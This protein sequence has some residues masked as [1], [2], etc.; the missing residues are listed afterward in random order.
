MIGKGLFEFTLDDG[1]KIGFKF[2]MYAAGLS[3]KSAGHSITEI[4]KRIHN[5]PD[6]TLS[7]L[8]YFYGGAV[9][10]N[11]STKGTEEI[12]LDKVSDWIDSL[13]LVKAMNLFSE[14]VQSSVPKN[15]K[16]PKETEGLGISQ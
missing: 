1:K 12:S 4:F 7:L 11:D 5:G 8:H 10:Y 3:E 9:A 15:G 6:R 16:A 13:G 14:S 2:G